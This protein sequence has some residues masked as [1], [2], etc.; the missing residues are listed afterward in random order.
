M[1]VLLEKDAGHYQMSLHVSSRFSRGREICTR[2]RF[3][4]LRVEEK[5]GSQSK[6]GEGRMFS[7]R[8]MILPLFLLPK[9]PF[10]FFSSYNLLTLIGEK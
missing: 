10:F 7:Q 3:A 2:F 5:Y 6:G 4:R 1:P 9:I 8:E